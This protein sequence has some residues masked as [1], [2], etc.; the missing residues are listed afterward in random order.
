MNSPSVSTMTRTAV[1]TLDGSAYGATLLQRLAR[2]QIPVH[3]AVVV[4]NGFGRK[5][6]LL[7]SVARRIGWTD[8][9]LYAIEEVV[10]STLR[11]FRRGAAPDYES[12]AWPEEL[13]KCLN[14]QKKCVRELTNWMPWETL[15]QQ[16]VKALQL[17]QPR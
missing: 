4:E 16:L 3:L 17:L 13:Q 10:A 1:I 9:S 11:N 8:A 7:R 5:W 14:F 15:L 12:L 6:R 2:R